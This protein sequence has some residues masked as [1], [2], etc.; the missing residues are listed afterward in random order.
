MF[1]AVIKGRQALTLDDEAEWVPGLWHFGEPLPLPLQIW[2]DTSEVL[3][4]GDEP[5]RACSSA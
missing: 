2:A 3:S 1:P 4:L 5:S